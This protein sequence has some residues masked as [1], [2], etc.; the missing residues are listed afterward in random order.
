MPKLKIASLRSNGIGWRLLS[1][2]GPRAEVTAFPLVENLLLDRPLENATRHNEDQGG[3]DK[4]WP[5]SAVVPFRNLAIT[6][7]P[8]IFKHHP[9]RE[10]WAQFLCEFGG[11]NLSNSPGVLCKPLKHENETFPMRSC[12][13]ILSC[14]TATLDLGHPMGQAAGF[15]T[16]Q[17]PL[18]LKTPEYPYLCQ[19]GFTQAIISYCCALHSAASC[20]R[21]QSCKSCPCSWLANCGWSH[22]RCAD[23]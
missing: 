16:K 3:R 11:S 4:S 7:P 23:A 9:R 12:V 10:G 8:A 14:K 5:R 21:R 17:K 20:L 6:I 19:H 1:P 18:L 2:S 22:S 15:V 13:R